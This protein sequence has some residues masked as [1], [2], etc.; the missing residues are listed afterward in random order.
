MASKKKRATDATTAAPAASPI[1]ESLR[2]L[3]TPLAGLK[4]D[5]RNARLHGERNLEAVKKSLADFGWRQVIVA[6]KKDG[7]VLAGN[8]RLEAAKA[9][10]WTEAPVLFVDDDKHRAMAFALADNRT[11]EMATWDDDRL[12]AALSELAAADLDTS[13]LWS[14]TEAEEVLTH[15]TEKRAAP[16]APPP[17]VEKPK[18]PVTKLGDLIILGPHRVLCGDSTSAKEVSRLLDGHRPLLMVTDPPYG[19][20]YD[21]VWRH[22]TGINKSQQTGKV[23][24]DDRAS[25]AAAWNHFRGDV[26]YVW[27]GGLA[28][29]AVE[30]SLDVVGFEVRAQIIWLKRR[31][32]IS[33][34]AYH[35]RHE[36]CFYAV[37]KGAK[38]SWVGGRKQD[39]AWA[40][41]VDEIEEG[42]QQ[43]LFTCQISNDRIYAFYASS[44]TVWEMPN[45]A[46]VGG[47][48][49]T[50][51]P[52]EAMARP[53]RNHKTDAVYDPFLGTGTTLVA[54]EQEGLRCFG[55]ELDPAW[56]D[57]I[58]GRWEALTGKKATRKSSPRS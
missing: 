18:R 5:P 47:G 28:S 42:Q 25:W 15:V 4:P 49:S 23:A 20:E 51:K 44:T 3:A 46:P 12:A 39:T 27:H 9:L 16:P 37:R 21:A 6:R 52:V 14:K 29:G 1:P 34:G 11:A 56:C 35:W 31:F 55:L 43:D 58:V 19:V 53:M 50:Q 7:I 2:F 32:A 57:V 17:V 54:A 26:A 33:R 22:R 36:P 24:N 10:G 45:D 30:R 13:W 48:H 40:D 41:V 8:A 38:A